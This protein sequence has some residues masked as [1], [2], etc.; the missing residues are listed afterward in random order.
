ML[1]NSSKIHLL[2][3]FK[4]S[5]LISN[6]FYKFRFNPF[7]NIQNT[8]KKSVF[9]QVDFNPYHIYKKNQRKRN[10]QEKFEDENYKWEIIPSP[11]KEKGKNLMHVLSQEERNKMIK[12]DGGRKEAIRLGDKIE[13]EYYHSMTSKKLHKYRG[14]VVSSKRPH[15]LT[16]SFKFLTMVAGSY[17]MLEYPYHSP[18]LHSIKVVNPSTLKK[19]NRRRHIYSIRKIKDFGNKLNEVIKGGKKMNINKAAKKELKKIESQKESIILE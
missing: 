9:D 11:V 5:Q 16:Y 2:S 14:V 15:S 19:D 3:G 6:A 13:V 1:T 8:K 7:L 10:T 4:T 17:V 12:I 18:M